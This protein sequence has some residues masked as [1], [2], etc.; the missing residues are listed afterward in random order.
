MIIPKF[1]GIAK[2]NK[3]IFDDRPLFDSYVGQFENQ[4]IDVTVKKHRRKRTTGKPDEK[5][6][7]NGWYWT[8][9]LPISANS[10]GYTVKE[11]HEVFI[12]E[13][14]PFTIREFKGKKIPI[15]RRTSEMDTVQFT[16]YVE[17]IRR[18]MAEMNVIIPD[19]QKI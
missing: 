1:Q 3:I 19:P 14:A 9:V 7:Q 10:L 13:Y 16:D 11:M 6:D 8:A 5:G 4:R 12:A 17:T 18:V 2:N 15:K